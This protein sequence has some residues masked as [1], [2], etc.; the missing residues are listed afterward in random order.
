MG[1]RH[2]A[3]MR[4][5]ITSH[6]YFFVN[7]FGMVILPINPQKRTFNYRGWRSASCPK[8]TFDAGEI[9]YNF[10]LYKPGSYKDGR[11]NFSM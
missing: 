7:F 8:E 10:L 9:L 6:I 4:E 1:G 3:H 2:T 5:G 11:F